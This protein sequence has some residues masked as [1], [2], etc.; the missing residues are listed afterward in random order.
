[1]YLHVLL[2]SITQSQNYRFAQSHLSGLLHDLQSWIKKQGERY[3]PH[4]SRRSS[5]S[6]ANDS[7]RNLWNSVPDFFS[8]PSQDPLT[9]PALWWAARHSS[10]KLSIKRRASMTTGDERSWLRQH[11]SCPGYGSS[12]LEAACRRYIKTAIYWDN[13]L[14]I[15]VLV[16]VEPGVG[17]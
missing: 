8:G 2:A 1:M 15:P 7:E 4:P 3:L 14:I 11:P 13:C 12:C 6:N 17:N 9:D 10:R 5:S 16:R